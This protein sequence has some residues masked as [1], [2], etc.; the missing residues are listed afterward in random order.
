MIAL[1]SLGMAVLS[2]LQAF[3]RFRNGEPEFWIAIFVFL[4]CMFLGAFCVEVNIW[5]WLKLTVKCFL[6]IL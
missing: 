5:H 3:I 2:G 1:I 4:A 6:G